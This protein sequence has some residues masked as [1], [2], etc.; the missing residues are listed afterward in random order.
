M[1][2]MSPMPSF[3]CENAASIREAPP[4]LAVARLVD[5]LLNRRTLPVCLALG[6]PVEK[7]GLTAKR[8]ALPSRLRVPSSEEPGI[9]IRDGDK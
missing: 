4:P 1:T 3:S 8:T 5:R 7:L 2:S 9:V 6:S